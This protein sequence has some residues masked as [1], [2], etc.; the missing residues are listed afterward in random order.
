MDASASTDPGDRT[1]AATSPLRH[2]LVTG[3]AGL[4]GSE[5]VRQLRA[6]GTG[7]TALL[8][9]PGAMDAERVLVGSM[10]DVALVR[11]AMA[12]VDA[13]I[14]CAALR[15]PMMG[16]PEAVFIGNTAGTFTV[17]EQAGQAGIHRAV[18]ASSY[19]VFGLVFAPAVLQP[20]YLPVDDA[21]PFQVADPYAHSKQVD[22]LTADLMAT[23]HGMTVVSLRLP[24]L[25]GLGDTIADRAARV[26]DDPA[27]STA[28]REFWTYL[29]TRDAAR[30]CILGL[31]EPPPGSHRITVAAPTTLAPYS[32][33]ALLDRYYPGVPRRSRFP[34][35]TAPFDLSNARRLLGFEAE[36]VVAIEE[37]DGLPEPAGVGSDG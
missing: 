24:F 31:T 18:I 19:S 22:E 9:R 16:T 1:G 29:D 32:T 12:G 5:I 2:V 25:G 7:V 20:A 11:E 3:A 36:H 34:G 33:E 15:N 27:H 30:A 35:R 6:R 4:L 26:A 17:L 13:V 23:R 37:R 28:A 10:D 8:H 21:L 14:H